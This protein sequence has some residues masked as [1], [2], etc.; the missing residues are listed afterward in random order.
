MLSK[1]ITEM[2]KEDKVKIR[3]LSHERCIELFYPFM[4]GYKQN[5]NTIKGFFGSYIDQP[6]KQAI[7]R[8]LVSMGDMIMV[9][10]K[11]LIKFI[12]TSSLMM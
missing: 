7:V 12:Y 10:E 8:Q 5:K 9:S 2:I 11:D 6:L 4:Y 1:E 3:N